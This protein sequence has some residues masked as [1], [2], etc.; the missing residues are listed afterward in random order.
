MTPPCCIYLH[1]AI[2]L[3]VEEFEQHVLLVLGG[4][5]QQDCIYI[6]TLKFYKYT[7]IYIEYGP[8]IYALYH[9]HITCSV[10]FYD[11]VVPVN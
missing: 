10:N 5:M 7:V 6:Q 9:T 4:L 11:T 1:C 2:R 3:L 8:S